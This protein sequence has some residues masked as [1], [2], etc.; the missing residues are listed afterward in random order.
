MERG[1]RTRQRILDRAVAVASQ[2]GL[3]GLTIG[4]LAGDLELSKS[5]LFAHFGSKEEL[6][7]QVLEEAIERFTRRVIRPTLQ[8]PR[9]AR[10]VRELF[11]RWLGWGADSGMPGGCVITA[12]AIELDDRPGAARKV[13]EAALIE[14]IKLIKQV[15]GTAVQEGDFRA[16]LD[17][18]QFT[19][20]LYAIFLAFHLMHRMIRDPAAESHARRSF[21]ALMAAAAA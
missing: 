16:G 1:E 17:V 12:A 20:D 19:Y 10:R 9:G 3:D 4:G 6:Q 5:G 14:W 8:A 15:V 11:D 13:L 2:D 7:I 18:A 21:D